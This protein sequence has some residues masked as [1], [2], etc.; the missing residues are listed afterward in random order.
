MPRLWF[1]D[2]VEDDEV[3]GW[4]ELDKTNDDYLDTLIAVLE[5]IANGKSRNPRV[6]A[7]AI[8]EWFAENHKK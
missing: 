3:L 2:I 6:L 4:L 1:G 5:C 8:V 7:E